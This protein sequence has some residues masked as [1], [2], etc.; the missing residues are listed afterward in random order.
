MVGRGSHDAEATAEMQRFVALRAAETPLEATELGFVAM[1]EPRLEEVLKDAADHAARRIVVQPHLLF[2]G[3]LLDRIGQ[4]VAQ[5]ARQRPDKDW[6]TT[7]HL[8]PSH[9]VARAIL[10]RARQMLSMG[11][12]D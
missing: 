1:A 3:V 4:M 2:G 7:A 10:S 6:L 9:L 11:G 12:G 5:Q 8:G